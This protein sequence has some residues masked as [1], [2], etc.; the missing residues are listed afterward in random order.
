M[1]HRLK[2]IILLILS[3][4]ICSPVFSQVKFSQLP[5]TN[6]YNPATDKLLLI[7]NGATSDYL[8]NLPPVTWPA[9]GTLVVSTGSNSPSGLTP[10]NGECVVGSG[11][12]WTV[13]SCSP[14]TITTIT[15]PG[16]TL[17]I[18]G[19][20]SNTT[21]DIDTSHANTWTGLQTFGFD[22]SIGGTTISGGV[23]GVGDTL[24]SDTNSN[25][26]G[27]YANASNV[28]EAKAG[29]ASLAILDDNLSGKD[30]FIENN[31]GLSANHSLVIN[32][33]N[34]DRTINLGGDLTIPLPLSQMA[35]NTANTL[36]GFD[37][38]GVATDISVSGG[39]S[40]SGGTLS[41]TGVPYLVG[42]GTATASGTHGLALGNGATGTGQYS[43]AIGYGSQ[44]TNLGTGAGNGSIAIGTNAI[45]KNNATAGN[46]AIVIGNGALDD[47]GINNQC[48]GDGC[49][50]HG[51]NYTFTA[52]SGASSSGAQ[53]V[54]IGNNAASTA[55]G[56]VVIGNGSQSAGTWGVAIG[57]GSNA[58][59]TGA[60]AI[61]INSIAN[62][63]GAISIGNGPNAFGMDSSFNFFLN[64]T[65][66]V[67][68]ITSA[69]IISKIDG[70]STAGWG[71]PA[72]YG[73]GRATAQ[74]AANTS[75]AT[76]TVGASD[77]SFIVDANVN[78][79]TSTT[80][81]FTVVV[82]YTDETNTSQTLT[83][84]F[85]QPAGTIAT[86]ITNVTGAGPYEGIPMHIRCKASTAITVKTTG[87]FTTVTYNIEGNIRQI[88]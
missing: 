58:N 51:A 18:G 27:F 73:N 75:V 53:A 86:A 29:G 30:L 2:Y 38:S 70:I 23:S 5:T 42:D 80:H 25:A 68:G 40:L 48:I 31:S 83:L 52:G 82:T 16:G 60:I 20:P 50:N 61:G 49:A 67:F 17:A 87:T 54:V 34:A 45:C 19:T 69:G 46:T 79:T 88:S 63:T 66:S 32:V 56:N 11:G 71:V 6:S 76:Y 65:S 59:G 1:F 84:N 33:N 21:I 78:V 47:N 12:V 3:L 41:A 14:G 74:T 8:M 22:I 35:A 44:V 10:I 43:I 13:G 64:N 55:N 4:F 7:R 72:I 9:S 36:L 62:G 85:A 57:Q 77:G 28:L 81:N 39:L 24:L 37:N 26:T 15:S